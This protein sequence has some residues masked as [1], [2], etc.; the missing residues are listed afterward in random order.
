MNILI[1]Y[2]SKR[3][4]KP[5][6]NIIKRT[7]L[8]KKSMTENTNNDNDNLIKNSSMS[9]KIYTKTGDKGQT[10]LLGGIRVNKDNEIFDLLGDVDELNSYL[11]LVK[12]RYFLKSFL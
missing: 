10:S 5:I 2:H 1:A 8:F 4:S 3:I 12:I 11:G 7:L 6:Y 9:F